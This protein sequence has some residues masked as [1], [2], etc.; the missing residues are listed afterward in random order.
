MKIGHVSGAN[1]SNLLLTQHEGG[2]S[3]LSSFN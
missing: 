3:L 2:L 1:V